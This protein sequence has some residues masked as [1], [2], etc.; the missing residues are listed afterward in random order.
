MR[1]I[2]W[3]FTSCNY[4]LFVLFDT[5]RS[6]LSLMKLW[7]M[8][9]PF[10]WST[11]SAYSLSRY[12]R[13][14]DHWLSLAHNRSLKICRN[15]LLSTVSRRS[16]WCPTSIRLSYWYQWLVMT[17]H[18]GVALGFWHYHDCVSCHCFHCCL[19]WHSIA[20]WAAIIA[21]IVQGCHG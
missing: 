2:V 16:K 15:L 1:I 14:V 18:A 19:C 7:S 20:A 5:L 6:R 17:S 13:H 10:L 9:W 12:H 8:D 21:F 4:Q 11:Q 3:C